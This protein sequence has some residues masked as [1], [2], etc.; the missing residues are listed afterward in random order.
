MCHG[1]SIR[2]GGPTA[3]PRGLQLIGVV[4][5]MLVSAWILV[6]VAAAG[7]ITAEQAVAGC[8]KALGGA[9]KVD[10]LKTLRF[11][12]THPEKNLQFVIEIKRPSRIR[13]ESGYILVFNGTRAGFLK[14]APSENGKDPG[15]QL[16]E[17]E[18]WKDFEVDI[19]FLFP[20]FFDYPSTYLGL[21]TIEGRGFHKL[22]VALPMGLRMT[23]LLDEKT[24]LPYK[25]IAHVP[26]GGVTYNPE[27]VLGDYEETGGVLFPRTFTSTGWSEKGR[28]TVTSVEVNIPLG[29]D[30]F[31][32][33]AGL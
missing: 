2:N 30:R 22:G 29:D 18:S 20:A 5:L 10:A 24:F 13:S 21:E 23:Y 15:P 16:V 11:K 12:I 28:A 6:P 25:I 32:M 14:G 26:S 27:R 33:P 3:S 4:S 17:A 31:E 7:P 1:H 9:E 8:A 19:A